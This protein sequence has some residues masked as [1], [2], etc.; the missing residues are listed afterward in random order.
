M[1]YNTN[2]IRN[3]VKTVLNKAYHLA[4]NGRDCSGPSSSVGKTWRWCRDS[5]ETGRVSGPRR[6]HQ[7][8]WHRTSRV[9]SQRDR[10]PGKCLSA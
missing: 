6:H 9:E 7:R 8:Y 10:K 4:W 1:I 3:Y 2:I 5:K